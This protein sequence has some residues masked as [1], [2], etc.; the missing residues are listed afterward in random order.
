MKEIEVSDEIYKRFQEYKKEMHEHIVEEAAEW[1]TKTGHD[2][3]LKV[4]V[5]IP[6]VTDSDALCALFHLVEE[7]GSPNFWYCFGFHS[8]FKKHE[9][10]E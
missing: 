7:E 8:W 9:V 5:P 3:K 1:L 2:V 4:G 6:L 10:E